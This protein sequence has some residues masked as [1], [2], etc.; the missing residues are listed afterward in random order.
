MEIVDITAR[1]VIDSRAT[2]TL[3]T[4]VTLSQGVIGRAMVPSGASTGTHEAVERRDGDAARYGGK[5]VLGAVESVKSEIRQ[6]LLGFD[7]TQQIEIDQTLIAL[8]GTPDKGRL[9]ANAILGASLAV[10]H[11]AAAA[12]GQPLYAFLAA[13]G[14]RT[15]PVPMAN[16]LNG[17]KHADD[18][19]DFQEFMVMPVGAP[20]FREGVRVVTEVYQ[21]LKARLLAGGLATGLGDEGGFAPSLPSNEAAIELILESI[22]RAGYEPGADVALAL[23]PASTELFKDG[24]YLLEKEGHSLSS[25]QL[26]ELWA[27]WVD[28]Y[29]IISIE[30]G[31]AEDDW[32][33][34]AQLTNRIGDQAQI[35]G[36]DLLV[37]NP[38]RLRR[39]ISEGSANSI[40]IKVNQIGTL[41]ETLQTIKMA[42]G[43][44]W[45]TV[46][47]HRS[48]ETEDTT[49]ADLAVAT[50]SGLIK[51]GAPA[52]SERVAKYNRLLRIEEELGDSAIYPGHDAIPQSTRLR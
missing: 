2:P 44:G 52:R 9:G 33:G 13:S 3:E 5:G 39:G 17:G 1:E 47:S 45:T 29:P 41:T 46:I 6:A 48:G 34:W 51:I 12:S 37:T 43:A 36:D 4:E 7:A 30:D 27:D 10:A 31:M 11:A 20:T 24:N 15:L 26:A 49:I 28:R 16:I 19:T 18:S 32:Q 42:H 21:A 38:A 14:A 23:D 8:D 35:V 22:Q 50:N 25:E 40:L